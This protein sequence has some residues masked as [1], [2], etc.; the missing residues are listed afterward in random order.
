MDFL[1]IPLLGIFAFVA[2][3]A[4]V[5]VSAAGAYLALTV[6]HRRNGTRL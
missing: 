3:V 1:Q 5:L 2:V 6:Y 4:N